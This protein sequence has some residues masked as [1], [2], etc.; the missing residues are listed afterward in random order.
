[1][2]QELIDY[3]RAWERLGYDLRLWT[4]RN[5]PELRNQQIFDDV[6]TKGYV[7]VGGGVQELGVWVQQADIASYE[8]VY[9]YG[10]IYANTD[11]EP[12]RHLGPLLD[13][14]GAW[15]GREDREA[16]CNALMGAPRHHPAFDAVIGELAARWW[17]SDR[18]EPMNQATGPGLLTR[19]FE[20]RDDVTIFDRDVFYPFNFL[21][22]D[23]EWDEFPAAWTKHHWGHTRA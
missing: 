21:E 17:V 9:E 18:F 2:R 20:R 7:N 19:V 1:M 6:A 13:G 11:I 10:G 15:A 4:E 23:R 5:L 22:M 12:L 16:I 3:G 14:V 8:L